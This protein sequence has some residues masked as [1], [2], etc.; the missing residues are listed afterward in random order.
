MEAETYIIGGKSGTHT[1]RPNIY[2]HLFSLF[3]QGSYKGDKKISRY[4]EKIPLGRRP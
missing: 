3:F 4:L 2:S 1:I